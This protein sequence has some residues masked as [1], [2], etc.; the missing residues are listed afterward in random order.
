MI[1]ERN[2]VINSPRV[3]PHPGRSAGDKYATETKTPDGMDHRAAIPGGGL[4][5]KKGEVRP[6]GITAMA[7]NFVGVN[8]VKKQRF[9]QVLTK[10]DEAAIIERQTKTKA[11]E[12]LHGFREIQLGNKEKK[13]KKRGGAYGGMHFGGY[14][15]FPAQNARW[16]PVIN[17]EGFFYTLWEGLMLPFIAFAAIV[18]PTEL[19]FYADAVPFWPVGNLSKWT[20][21]MWSMSGQR[22]SKLLLSRSVSTR[23][24]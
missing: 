10:Q 21:F 18:T 2:S 11:D 14:E 23:F 3:A 4:K 22:T 13:K 15:N 16:F 1:D 6:R 19:A 5:H 17:P 24:G 9:S 12:M 7:L 8:R 20:S